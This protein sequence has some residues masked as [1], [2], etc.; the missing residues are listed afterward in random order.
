MPRQA[1]LPLRKL[2]AAILQ[3]HMFLSCVDLIVL[4]PQPVALAWKRHQDPVGVSLK[5]PYV[6]IGWLGH[7]V[8][9]VVAGC[10]TYLTSTSPGIAIA[11]FMTG[12]RS[13]LCW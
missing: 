12:K 10:L 9:H 2:G 4:V 3:L 1:V 7:W 5:P 13:P 11:K 6:E 8:P